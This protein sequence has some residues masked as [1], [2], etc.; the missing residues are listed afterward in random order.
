MQIGFCCGRYVVAVMRLLY[1]HFYS[2]THNG[3]ASTTDPKR[4]FPRITSGLTK[5]PVNY[6][7]ANACKNFFF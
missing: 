7:N 5:T 4:H 2:Y 3:D 1:F 6:T